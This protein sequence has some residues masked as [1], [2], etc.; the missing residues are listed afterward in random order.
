MMRTPLYSASM[1]GGI[2]PVFFDVDITGVSDLEISFTY[3]TG[4]MVLIVMP[5]WP[6]WNCIS[7]PVFWK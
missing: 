2:K 5:S 3:K 4:G 6:M 7:R 1:R